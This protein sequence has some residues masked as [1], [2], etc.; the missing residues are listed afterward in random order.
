MSAFTDLR[1]SVAGALATIAE[2]AAGTWTVHADTVDAVSPPAFLLQWSDPWF[3]PS[4]VCTYN[5]A[6]TVLCVS[7]RMDPA[8]GVETLEQMAP[9]VLEVLPASVAVLEGLPPAP[10]EIGGVRYLAARVNVRSNVTVERT[11]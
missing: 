6:L 1:A 11:D 7:A 2:V 10:F 9:A 8:P 4:S 3:N 5:A